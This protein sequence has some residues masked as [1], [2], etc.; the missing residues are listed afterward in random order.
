MRVARKGFSGRARK[1]AMQS[2]SDLLNAL[3]RMASSPQRT[4]SIA[5]IGVD[6]FSRLRGAIGYELAEQLVLDLAQR[7]LR[8]LP[9]AV[10]ARLAPDTIGVAF[11]VAGDWKDVH[12]H[13]VHLSGILE[14]SHSLA[15]HRVN[16]NIRIGFT[17]K[18]GDAGQNDTL[19]QYAEIALDQAREQAEQ[20]KRFSMS[21]FGDPLNR[22]AL[23]T[24][25][26]HAVSNSEMTL[27]YQPQLQTSTGKIVAAE[28]LVRW[29]NPKR[30]MVPPDHFIPTAE[31]TGL[32]GELTEW[33]IVRA[34][35][36]AQRLSAMGHPLRIGVNISGRLICDPVFAR[37]AKEIATS[38]P[39]CLT[40]E[41]TESIAIQDWA[42][43][44]RTLREFEDIGIRI[45]IDD[46]GSGVSSLA[47]VQQI[48]AQELKI[49]RQ[50][51]TQITTTN[52]DPLLV[53]STIELG[54]ALDFEVV[55]EGVEDS[56][57]LALLTQ[58]GCDLL[59]GYHIGAPMP[60]DHLVAY[61][62]NRDKH[63]SS[64]ADPRSTLL[65]IS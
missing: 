41:V 6:R 13:L 25:L 39:G 19:L 44:L 47:Y 60:I 59:Q 61:L 14:Q 8:N 27:H 50:F 38:V 16:V 54:H 30:G 57:T 42:T 45:S 48:P 18:G 1:G 34:A 55:A 53:R 46:Y 5:V 2:R 26:R 33:V 10:V 40:F 37:R 20:V 52:R 56:E 15:G 4:A 64:S 28:A 35:E 62:K 24:D 58:M 23:M 43:A 29:V 3:S 22:L 7:T 17:L 51:I 63:G 12:A 65:T 32:I 9:G 49:D 36:D 31:E 11:Q 21:E